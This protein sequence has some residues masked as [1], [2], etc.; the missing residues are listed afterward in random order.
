[1]GKPLV[2]DAKKLFGTNIDAG[3]LS[4]VKYRGSQAT[5]SENAVTIVPAQK[6]KIKLTYKYLNKTYK[7]IVKVNKPSAKAK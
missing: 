4:L 1:N 2:L 3:T 7:Y 5:L 6:D